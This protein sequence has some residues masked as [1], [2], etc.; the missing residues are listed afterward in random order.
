MDIPRANT[1]L[2]DRADRFGIADLYQLRGRVGR[3][4]RKAY[5]LLLLPPQGHI[6]SDARK[7]IGA[8]RKYSSLSAGF[9]LALRDLEIRGAGNL[10]GTA[11]SGHITAIGFGL[12]CQLLKRTVARLK[13]EPVP[14]LVDVDVT[15]DFLDLSPVG[16]PSPTAAGIPYNYISDEGLRV[17]VYRQLA[18]ASDNQDLSRLE[19]ELIDRF[20]PLPTATRRLLAISRIR[21]CS[22]DHGIR[23]VET[24]D[25]KL[26]LTGPNDYL[27]QGTRFP[28]L[29]MEEV[30]ARLDEIM[31]LIETSATWAR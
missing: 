27:M 11:Q 8:L 15:F 6:D 13:G 9:N 2:I 7:R 28:R 31:E 16:A 20:G 3:S 25:D 26:M 18:E 14:R 12:Y 24:R 4:S 19:E 17:G 22:A 5:A 10:L 1:I 21:I 23:R 29:T 30:E